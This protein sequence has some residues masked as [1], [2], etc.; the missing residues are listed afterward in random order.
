MVDH[1]LSNGGNQILNNA[2]GIN[3]ER[4]EEIIDKTVKKSGL[5]GKRVADALILFWDEQKKAFDGF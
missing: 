1:V 3:V 4:V 2:F 5:N